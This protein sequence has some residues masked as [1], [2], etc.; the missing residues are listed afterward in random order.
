MIQ[1][2]TTHQVAKIYDFGLESTQNQFKSLANNC[3]ARIIG[4]NVQI[5][6]SERKHLS[7]LM[8]TMHA[9][10]FHAERLLLS[11]QF[12]LA[13]G[14]DGALS[15]GEMAPEEHI[16]H[17]QPG[18]VQSEQAV[19]WLQSLLSH[20]STNASEV[21][22]LS[23]YID[24]IKPGTRSQSIVLTSDVARLEMLK[25]NLM[26]GLK[27]MIAARTHAAFT[28]NVGEVLKDNFD[29][30]LFCNHAYIM[31]AAIQELA[32]VSGVSSHQELALKT[33]LDTSI[34]AM[35]ALANDLPETHFMYGITIFSDPDQ[36]PQM[37]AKDWMASSQLMSLPKPH[38]L[39]QYPGWYTMSAENDRMLKVYGDGK[40]QALSVGGDVHRISFVFPQSVFDHLH[41]KLNRSMQRI[42]AVKANHWVMPQKQGR[43]KPLSEKAQQDA[44]EAYKFFQRYQ[45]ILQTMPQQMRASSHVSF[46]QDT[47]RTFKRFVRF[48]R[49]R[50]RQLKSAQAQRWMVSTAEANLIKDYDVAIESFQFYFI[51]AK[52]AGINDPMH[53]VH[54]F[55]GM[56]AKQSQHGSYSDRQ[57]AITKA[58]LQQPTKAVQKDHKA[59]QG[60]AKS[61]ETQQPSSKK[62]SV[63]SQGAK[64]VSQKDWFTWQ[65]GMVNRHQAALS[66]R[67]WSR[68][69]FHAMF[70]ITTMSL[71]LCADLMVF[72]LLF[73]LW[74]I[75][76]VFFV[77]AM[78]QHVGEAYEKVYDRPETALGVLQKISPKVVS[79]KV[80]NQTMKFNRLAARITGRPDATPAD[81]NTHADGRGMAT[82]IA[83]E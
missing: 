1:Q 48:M 42:D 60:L 56:D 47:D 30:Q 23:D 4:G 55:L 13:F 14:V 26:V 76:L 40:H 31:K 36:L 12:D 34:D 2:Y 9:Y 38:A 66:K 25:G 10:G 63:E 74:P 41:T 19:A 65:E 15:F 67:F 20:A 29:Q 53:H 39:E 75:P 46:G 70:L 11:Q 17:L 37:L 59:I 33:M 8:L 77:S 73:V 49:E 24:P 16:M 62:A 44:Q 50:Q 79:A 22:R 71:L 35:M 57:E 43:G 18:A 45:T 78:S 3:K 68:L 80:V 28:K 61:K 21:H 54:G 27:R 52:L 51:S 64:K 69:D 7:K 81:E 32:P 6:A 82:A 5:S 83:V 58:A 72:N